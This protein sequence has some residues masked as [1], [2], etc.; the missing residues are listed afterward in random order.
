ML[1]NKKHL[2]EAILIKA[3]IVFFFFFFFFCLKKEVRKIIF[4]LSADTALSRAVLIVLVGHAKRI[5]E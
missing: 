4:E 3:H 2:K 5:Q 1:L